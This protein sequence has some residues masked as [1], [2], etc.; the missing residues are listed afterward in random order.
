M[1]ADE[2]KQSAQDGYA[3][4]GKGDADAAMANIADSIQWVVGGDSS[5]S[6]T[7]NGK[8]DVMGF[9]GKLLEVGFS[10]NPNEFLADGDKVVVLSTVSVG[11]ESRDVA[12][13]LSYND[14]GN[15]IRFQSFGGEDLLNQTFPK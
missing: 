5:V 10:T 7:Y 1:S 9:W 14:D 4:F 3:A 13:V 2:Q 6:G 15:L 11:G 8:G 12:D